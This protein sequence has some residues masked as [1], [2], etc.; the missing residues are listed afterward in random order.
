MHQLMQIHAK[1]TQE[2][3]EATDQLKKILAS[4][5]DLLE[6]KSSLQ[7][8]LIVPEMCETV[9]TVQQCLKSQIL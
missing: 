8:D 6:Q 1:L 9:M 2:I 5:Q 7:G 3:E 4:T